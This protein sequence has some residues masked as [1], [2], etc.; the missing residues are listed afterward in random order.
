[1]NST[2]APNI[3]WRIV[4]WGT[5]LVL[6]ALPWVAMQFT[7]EVRWDLGD[8]IVF[9]AMLAAA[10]GTLEGMVRLTTSRSARAWAAALVGVAFVLIWAELAVGLLH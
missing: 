3:P 5:A 4:L 6:L 1:M 10:G 8:F 7:T 2:H 9:S